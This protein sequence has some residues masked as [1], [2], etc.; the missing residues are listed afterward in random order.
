MLLYYLILLTGF[1]FVEAKSGICPPG[2]VKSTTSNVCYIFSSGI[3]EFS[4]AQFNCEQQNG[5]LADIDS[6]FS[7]TQ[8]ATIA[9]GKNWDSYWIGATLTS[10]EI[11][12]GKIKIWAWDKLKKFLEYKNWG[13]NEPSNKGEC[14]AVTAADGLWFA[15]NC[16]AKKNYV[17]L[18]SMKISVCDDE[19]TYFSV[20]NFCYKVYYLSN[21]NNAESSCVA[22]GAH[23]VSIHSKEEDLFVQEFA[24]CGVTNDDPETIIG[25]YTTTNDNTIW[26]WSDGT[27]T[28][29]VPWPTG[30]PNNPGVEKC[31]LVVTDTVP[32]F[33]AGYWNNIQCD[34]QKRNYVCKKQPNEIEIK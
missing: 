8:L 14:A 5:I 17:C 16:S 11:N 12:D 18:V 30:E 27:P 22:L 10:V 23:L 13:R 21:W 7:N 15:E 9:E 4:E 26:N 6:D 33:P 2:S 32:K 1:T 19:W 28:D 31:V 29:Y 34:T 3:A 24:R 20:T 25:L